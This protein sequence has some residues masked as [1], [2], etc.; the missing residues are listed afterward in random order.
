MLVRANPFSKNL[1]F[2]VVAFVECF[3]EC[4]YGDGAEA[5]KGWGCNAMCVMTDFG[6]HSEEEL[7][8]VLKDV[9]LCDES[10]S[11]EKAV[12]FLERVVS[13]GV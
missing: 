12:A 9:K 5:S 13:G 1:L 10:V 8:Q 6:E 11:D 2:R 4:S 7:I 3:I